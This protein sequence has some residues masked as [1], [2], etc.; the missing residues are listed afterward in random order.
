MRDHRDLV[1][2]LHPHLEMFKK[3][4]SSRYTAVNQL[5]CPQ[6]HCLDEVCGLLPFLN[7]EVPD[8]FYRLWLSLFLHAGYVFLNRFQRG[9]KFPLCNMNYILTA[10]QYSAET[11]H[12]RRVNLG[13]QPYLCRQFREQ[14]N[15]TQQEHG[16]ND[17]R[18]V[19]PLP[20]SMGKVVA[21]NFFS[22]WSS[23]KWTLQSSF[24]PN[25]HSK[26]FQAFPNP[27]SNYYC[28]F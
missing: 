17:Q 20:H 1:F 12:F 19:L 25:M 7:P 26:N 13:F 27:S 2:R 15:S 3:Y 10:M 11:F 8:Q 9:I 16:S 22:I 4:L 28:M 18:E 5:L 14:K 24:K 21:G 23:N 6:V